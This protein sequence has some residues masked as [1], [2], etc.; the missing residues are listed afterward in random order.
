MT[1]H[2]NYEQ[3]VRLFLP[4]GLLDYFNITNIILDGEAVNVHLEESNLPPSEY[5]QD[6]L[7]SKGF[8]P[9]ITVQDF[10][11]RDKALLLHLKRRRWM[12]HSTGNIV[13]R[14]WQ[15]V[16]SGTRLTKGFAS[17]LKGA[18]GI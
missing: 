16:A 9:A 15:L 4:E 14:D 10:P 5:A 11:L 12:N 2:E 1:D 6:K 8:I 17:F 7:E 13:S 3:L 18:F